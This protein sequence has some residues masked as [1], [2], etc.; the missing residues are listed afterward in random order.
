M[1]VTFDS[2][3]L[4]T[5]EPITAEQVGALDLRWTFECYA[6][7]LSDISTLS[8]KGGRCRTVTMLNG[9]TSVQTT[10]TVGTLAIDGTSHTNCSILGPIVIREMPA[11]AKAKWFYTVTIVKNTTL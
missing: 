1:T 7:A 10:G 8:G 9:K 4:L 2:T 11:S 5:R 3:V 6:A